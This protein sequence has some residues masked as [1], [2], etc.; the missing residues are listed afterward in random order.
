[1][2]SVNITSTTNTVTVTGDGDNAVVT[3]ATVGPQGPSGEVAGGL[4][5][6]GDPGNILIKDTNANYD[7]SWT[8]TLDGG[9]FN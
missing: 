4:P 8:A 3:V 5:T 9:T 7:A 2:T 1:M 6:G